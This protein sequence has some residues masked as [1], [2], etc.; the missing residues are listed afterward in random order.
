MGIH[1][2]S[3][4]CFVS[5]LTIYSIQ[6]I[7]SNQIKCGPSCLHPYLIEQTNKRIKKQLNQIE[8]KKQ[9]KTNKSLC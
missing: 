5:N 7:K 2:S 1:P 9:K 8:E 4:H 6:R 3:S